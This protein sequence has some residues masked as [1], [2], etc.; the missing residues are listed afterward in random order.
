MKLLLWVSGEAVCVCVE[1][2]LRES[3]VHKN[4]ECQVDFITRKESVS[5]LLPAP[6]R[7][8]EN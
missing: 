3:S 8:L 7:Q 6:K 1:G 2:D 4:K 5:Y